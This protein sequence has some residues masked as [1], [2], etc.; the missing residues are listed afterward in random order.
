MEVY[1]DL[2]PAGWDREELDVTD[3][4]QV[5]P[6]LKEFK[7]DL[8]INCTAYNDVD[9]AEEDRAVAEAINGL[10]PGYLAAVC[11]EM[12]AVFVHFST[13]QVFAGD[14][15]QGYNED[16]VPSP[17]NTYGRSKLMGEM[18]VEKNTEK[19]YLIRTAWLYGA[20]PS[21]GK[22]KSFVDIMLDLAKKD[23]PIKGVDDEFGNPTYSLDLAQAVRAMIEEKK[24]FGVYHLVNE[25]VASRLDWMKEIFIIK[26]M[27][28]G[29]VP[30][31]R[32]EFAGKRKAKR[33][34]YEVLNNTKFIKLRPW[35]EALKEYLK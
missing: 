22:K 4:E 11:A 24:P 16:D 31:S 19:Y 5:K 29:I 1:A 13:G 14:N 9:G 17:L 6:K 34:Q 7:P 12:D 32:E 21:S 23:R 26:E 28:V 2:R 35:T 10:A 20:G 18:E 3:E 25:G 30:V 33:P 8:V 15:S 27:E